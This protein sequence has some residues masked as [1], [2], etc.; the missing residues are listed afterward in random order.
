MREGDGVAARGRGA[1]G[2]R[3]VDG[4]AGVVS[5]GGAGPRGMGTRIKD[6]GGADAGVAALGGG[7]PTGVVGREYCVG[8]VECGLRGGE[9]G[10]S[11][12]A[13]LGVGQ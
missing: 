12:M 13:G 7:V 2:T 1:A 6:G 4:G 8:D 5:R 9:V 11:C 3:N 10:K